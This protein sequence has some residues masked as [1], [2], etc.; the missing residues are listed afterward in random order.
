[1]K[2][3]II[4]LGPGKC[5][6]S[7]IQHFFSTCTDPCL[8]R[9]GFLHFKPA[10]IQ[11]VDG[12][13]AKDSAQREMAHLLEKGFGGCEKLIVSHEML[14]KLPGVVRTI[15]DLAA[16]YT[17]DIRCVG[18]CRRQSNFI[19]SAYS[20]WFFRS[21]ERV[22]EIDRAVCDAGW[23][24]PLFSGLERQFM[25][26][27]IN[28][29]HSARQLSGDSILDW[30]KSYRTLSQTLE[31]TGASV[32]C[33]TLP[34]S[35]AETSL[36][37]AF[38][39]LSGLTLN[40]GRLEGKPRNTRYD[41]DL[42]EG[43][44]A[45]VSL[46]IPM[47]GPHENNAW[48]GRVSRSAESCKASDSTEFFL[49]LKSYT[50]SYFHASNEKLCQKFGLNGDYFKPREVYDKP[51]IIGLIQ[52]ENEK[53]VANGADILKACRWRLARITAMFADQDMTRH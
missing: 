20:Q 32:H 21:V 22:R 1:M 45:A 26:S 25:A 8:E 37:E 6:S 16:E 13:Q 9:T 38:C 3:L 48:L 24:A 30:E 33:G 28:D 15:V 17:S 43:I 18:F 42:V 2:A 12:E 11:A 47:P 14:F 19:V 53:R 5:G 52:A 31:G 34:D 44:N 29:F 4:H 39:R 40:A 46:G 35:G 41:P 50:D 49:A 51:E 10:L 27:V 7:S 23:Q 36:I